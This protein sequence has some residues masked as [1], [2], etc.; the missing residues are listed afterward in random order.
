[1][2]L[3][4]LSQGQSLPCPLTLTLD[5]IV[6]ILILFVNLHLK[7]NEELEADRETQVCL[8]ETILAARRAHATAN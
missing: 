7:H 1:M 5:I 3:T 8:S 4:P 2:S 6:V